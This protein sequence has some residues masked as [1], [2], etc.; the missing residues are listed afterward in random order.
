MKPLA[1]RLNILKIHKKKKNKKDILR[2]GDLCTLFLGCHY[3]TRLIINISMKNKHQVF[4]ILIIT[5]TMFAAGIGQRT[6]RTEV[7]EVISDLQ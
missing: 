1:A 7:V 3:C 5:Y 2:K 4:K 6:Y